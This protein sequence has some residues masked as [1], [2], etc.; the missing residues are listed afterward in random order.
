VTFGK[1]RVYRLK[2][3]GLESCLIEQASGGQGQRI[4]LLSRCLSMRS[5]YAFVAAED[6]SRC[7]SLRSAVEV[8][9][10]EVCVC[11]WRCLS[12]RSACVCLPSLRASLLAFLGVRDSNAR[13][14][15]GVTTWRGAFWALSR[16]RFKFG[17]EGGLDM[18]FDSV[19]DPMSRGGVDCSPPLEG[20]FDARTSLLPWTWIRELPQVKVRSVYGSSQ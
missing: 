17:T 20:E 19:V 14:A 7:L 2:T 9:V 11:L 13:G 1:H 15:R 12:L 5:A 18:Y 8:P 4:G 16:R 6:P 3:N 10:I